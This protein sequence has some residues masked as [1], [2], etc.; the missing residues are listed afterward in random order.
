MFESSA[1]RGAHVSR[2][3]VA[4]THASG[5]VEN[6]SVKL[7]LSGKISDALNGADRFVDAVTPDGDQLFLSKEDI[8]RV[9]LVDVPKVSQLNFYRRASDKAAFDPYQVLKVPRGAS[10]DEIKHAYHRMVRLYHPD[11]IGN[12]ELPDEMHEYA[13]V[14]LVRINLAYEQIGT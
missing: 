12:F 10:H 8:R 14:M 11:R 13:R 9:A 5:K 2:C 3:L 7:P 4:V 6:Y 1:S